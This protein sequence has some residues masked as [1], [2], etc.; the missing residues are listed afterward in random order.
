MSEKTEEKVNLNQWYTAKEAAERLGTSTKY[1]R[2][3]GVQYKKFKTHKLHEHLMLYWKADV[4]AYGKVEKRK[5]GRPRKDESTTL[6]N[7]AA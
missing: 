5:R 2:T 7:N 4:D 6:D 1:V 3:M